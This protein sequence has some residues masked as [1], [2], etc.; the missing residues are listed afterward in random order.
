MVAN[1]MVTASTAQPQ[2]NPPGWVDVI[3]HQHIANGPHRSTIRG[4]VSRVGPA[5]RRTLRPNRRTCRL[6]SGMRCAHPLR[7]GW[8]QRLVRD[9]VRTIRLYQDLMMLAQR[10]AS[11][12]R[13]GPLALPG[14]C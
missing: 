8:T 3:D 12:G 11:G 13:T 14:A 7:H 10:Y 2:A 6:R 4:R 9:P 1:L 5:R